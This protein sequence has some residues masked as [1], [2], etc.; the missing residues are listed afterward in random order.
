M[1]MGLAEEGGKRGNVEKGEEEEIDKEKEEEWFDFGRNRLATAVTR[2][3]VR[4]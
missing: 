1:A 4:V 2:C 3:I